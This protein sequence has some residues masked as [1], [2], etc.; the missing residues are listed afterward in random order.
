MLREG[1]LQVGPEGGGLNG[2]PGGRED[3]VGYSLSSHLASYLSV[4]LNGY[5]RLP[6]VKLYKS[7]LKITGSALVNSALVPEYYRREG[8]VEDGN[9]TF[10]EYLTNERCNAPSSC[11]V[12][13]RRRRTSRSSR[14]WRI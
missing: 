1:N 5:S 6:D 12:Q 4:L 3:S 8:E 2:S 7:L 14:S 10:Q 9:L 11:S 13:P